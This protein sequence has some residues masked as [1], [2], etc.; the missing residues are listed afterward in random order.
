LGKSAR[1]PKSFDRP[2]VVE[3]KFVYDSTSSKIND[4]QGDER[5]RQ[6]RPEVQ[7][8]FAKAIKGRWETRAVSIRVE[9]R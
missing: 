8:I 7:E 4:W 1:G 2:G 6:P 5:G 9:G 3:V